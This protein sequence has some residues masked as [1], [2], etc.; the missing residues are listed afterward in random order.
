MEEQPGMASVW[1]LP[2]HA[3]C[4]GLTRPGAG[5]HLL[6]SIHLEFETGSISTIF[7]ETME[8]N[9]NI[10]PKLRDSRL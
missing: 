3:K 9:Q 8:I 7:P 6:N 1:G 10:N 5:L 2:D 4:G